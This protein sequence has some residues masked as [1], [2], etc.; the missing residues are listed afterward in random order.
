[1]EEIYYVKVIAKLDV[2]KHISFGSVHWLSIYN[3]I[4]TDLGRA[5]QLVMS[6]KKTGPDHL[7]VSN[8]SGPKIRCI[9]KWLKGEDG[10]EVQ[11]EKFHSLIV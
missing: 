1:M 5:V 7:E 9:V 11:I 8:T 10:I 3:E 6:L 2:Q 4:R